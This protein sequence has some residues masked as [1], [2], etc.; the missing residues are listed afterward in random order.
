MNVLIDTNVALDYFLKREGFAENAKRVFHELISGENNG[1]LSSSVVTDIYY[2]IRRQKCDAK[3]ARKA[4]EE[5]HHYLTILTVSEETIGK[6]LVLP[7]PDFEDAVQA[8]A[9]H[10]CHIDIVVTRDKTGFLDS[11]LNVYS[12]EEFLEM[13]ISAI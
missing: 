6:A 13:L 1:C 11:G 8:A 3:I 5:I 9:A 4:V 2:C 10:D 7:M 12:P